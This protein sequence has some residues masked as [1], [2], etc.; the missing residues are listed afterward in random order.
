MK[1]K[2][3]AERIG[4]YVEFASVKEIFEIYERKSL[5]SRLQTVTSL[6]QGIPREEYAMLAAYNAFNKLDAVNGLDR[7]MKQASVLLNDFKDFKLSKEDAEANKKDKLGIPEPVVIREKVLFR[8]AEYY[9][10]L[11]TLR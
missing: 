6:T 10:P 2:E 3:F 5:S 7:S 8:Y 9:A 11:S 1:D 4:D